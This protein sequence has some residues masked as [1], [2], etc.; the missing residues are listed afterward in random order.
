MAATHTR[1][2]SLQRP[3]LELFDCALGPSEFHCDVANALLL[4]EAFDDDGPLVGRK[5]IDQPEQNDA[6]F[7]VRPMRLIEVVGSWIERLS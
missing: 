3:E 5:I 2:Q 7:N 1:A 4:N 6:T